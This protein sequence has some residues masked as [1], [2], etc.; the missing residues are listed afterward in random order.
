MHALKE[1]SPDTSDSV[2]RD[3]QGQIDAIN[4]VQVVIEFSLDGTIGSAN[5]NFLNA[6]GYRLEEIQGK[7]HPMFCDD[8]Y[9]NSQAY[10]EFWES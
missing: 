4:R 5:P 3:L 1:S 6:L 7:H 10:R 2:S 8:E 9:V